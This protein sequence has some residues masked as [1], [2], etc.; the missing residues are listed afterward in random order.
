M[1]LPRTD[2][3][4]AMPRKCLRPVE[5]TFMSE[6]PVT[7]SGSRKLSF[8]GDYPGNNPVASFAK[9]MS[10]QF[11]LSPPAVNLSQLSG[12]VL[13]LRHESPFDATSE[14]VAHDDNVVSRRRFNVFG[15]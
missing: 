13:I 9:A 14:T 8:V 7:R 10:T 1:R 2:A 5:G 4:P 6:P 12:F 11:R 15:S 3:I